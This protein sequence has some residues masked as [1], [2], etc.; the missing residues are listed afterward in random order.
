[1]GVLMRNGINYSGEGTKIETY[2]A[3]QLFTYNSS[4]GDPQK[5]GLYKR[6]G[7]DADSHGGYF[8]IIDDHILIYDFAIMVVNKNYT[9]VTSGNPKVADTNDLFNNKI[10]PFIKDSITGNTSQFIPTVVYYNEGYPD[11]PW[12]MPEI[13][14]RK[15]RLFHNGTTHILSFEGAV[16]NNYNVSDTFRFQGTIVKQ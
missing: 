3:D 10:V 11:E 13:V 14:N 12:A 2:T 9:Y 5:M 1:M 4:F 15:C 8:V 6:L 7:G 16:A